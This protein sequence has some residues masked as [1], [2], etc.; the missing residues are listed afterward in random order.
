MEKAEEGKSYENSENEKGGAI[1]TRWGSHDCP[2]VKG[3]KL[4]YQGSA[5]QSFYSHTG[6]AA[7][8]LCLPQDP[9]FDL[10]LT[11]TGVQSCTRIL[12]LIVSRMI[13]MF[14]VQYV[15]Q[16]EGYPSS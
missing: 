3:T 4:I 9:D 10:E 13:T 1:Y 7:N 16:E 14:P 15:G 6:G 12:H 8:Y 5:A 11:R 2:D